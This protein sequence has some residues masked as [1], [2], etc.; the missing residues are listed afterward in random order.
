MTP[1]DGDTFMRTIVAPLADQVS[2]TASSSDV[3]KALTATNPTFITWDFPDAN[4]R[5]SLQRASRWEF[6][7]NVMCHGYSRAEAKRLA[8]SAWAAMKAAVGMTVDGLSVRSTRSE[9]SPVEIR[10][11]GQST[12]HHRYLAAFRF[13]VA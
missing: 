3:A 10:F 7:V 6:E 13:T 5:S 8:A 2:A 1:P 9:R 12:T 4:S 11:D